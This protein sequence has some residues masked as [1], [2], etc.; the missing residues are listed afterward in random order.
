MI[1][2]FQT[3]NQPMHLESTTQMR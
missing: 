2:A 3:Y 1:K